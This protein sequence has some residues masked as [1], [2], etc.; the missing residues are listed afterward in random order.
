MN[1]YIKVTL[2]PVK[3]NRTHEIAKQLGKQQIAISATAV[4]P[5]NCK[6]EALKFS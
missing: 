1:L 2:N 3:Q 6:Y 4:D 5:P